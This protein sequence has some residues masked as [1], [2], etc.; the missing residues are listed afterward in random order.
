MSKPFSR[1]TSIRRAPLGTSNSFPLIVSLANS[2]AIYVFATD[3][4]DLHR[5]IICRMRRRHSSHLPCP[6]PSVLSVANLFLK[7]SGKRLMADWMGHDAASP[8]GQNDLPSMLSQRSSINCASSGRPAP[9]S[10]RLKTFTSQ[11]V[12]SRHGVHQPHDSC[13]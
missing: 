8:S 6:C 13:L 9:L 3:Y 2:V 5:Q 7:S 10:I 11:S 12:P 1:H 4:T